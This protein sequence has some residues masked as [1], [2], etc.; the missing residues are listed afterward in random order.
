MGQ[1]CEEVGTEVAV[2][3]AR[4]A[5]SDP[6]LLVEIELEGHLGLKAGLAQSEEAKELGQEQQSPTTL[7]L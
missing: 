4:L 3:K 6:H 7:V 5:Q 1:E 2:L